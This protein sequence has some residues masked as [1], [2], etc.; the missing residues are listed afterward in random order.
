MTVK[1]IDDRRR[2]GRRFPAIRQLTSTS[3]EVKMTDV[4]IRDVPDEVI[5]AMDAHADRLG[6]SRSEYMRRLLARDAAASGSVASVR[7]LARFAEVFSDLADPDV[8]AQAWN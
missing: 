5:A 3:R 7:V 2:A 1:G 6:L 8:M 4:L